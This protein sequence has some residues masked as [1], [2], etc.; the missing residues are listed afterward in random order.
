MVDWDF[1]L[2]VVFVDTLGALA[3]TVRS[4]LLHP[5]IAR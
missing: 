5:V 2:K 4:A 3:N 1:G